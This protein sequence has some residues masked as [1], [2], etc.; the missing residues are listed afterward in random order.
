MK[1]QYFGERFAVQFRA[2]FFNLFNIQNYDTPGVT[3]GGS[4]FG[5]VTALTS[6][7][8]PRQIQFSLRASF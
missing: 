7:A 5:V 8:P 1:Q 6:G 3:Y 4:N 2:E